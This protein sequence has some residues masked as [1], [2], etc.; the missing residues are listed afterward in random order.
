M[1]IVNR[2]INIILVLGAMLISGC[3]DQSPSE[4][5]VEA[6]SVAY[7]QEHMLDALADPGYRGIDI[8]IAAQ[9]VEEIRVN[10]RYSKKIDGDTFHVY[11]IEVAVK[12]GNT[13]YRETI[14]LALVK[15]GE[16]WK[17]TQIGKAKTKPVN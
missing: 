5:A 4:D 9:K 14:S 11:D 15:R 12:L 6:A 8:R 13:K 3:G 2:S 17:W 7:Y 10:N 16:E 1:K